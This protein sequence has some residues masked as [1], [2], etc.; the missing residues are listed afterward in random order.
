MEYSSEMRAYCCSKLIG[1]SSMESF[2]WRLSSRVEP[3]L[4]RLIGSSSV[5]S[6]N[7]P[8]EKWLHAWGTNQPSKK[9]LC[10]WGREMALVSKMVPSMLSPHYWGA[11]GSTAL[12]A[13]EPLHPLSSWGWNLGRVSSCTNGLLFHKLHINFLFLF[14]A[15]THLNNY[16]CTGDYTNGQQLNIKHYL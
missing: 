7:Q 10:T 1:S 6:S 9:W 15:C 11:N 2:L 3:F 16:S 5:E 13:R 8:S 12:E 4:W 14:F